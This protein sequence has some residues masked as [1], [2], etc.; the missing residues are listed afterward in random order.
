[1]LEL[2]RASAGSGKTY[3]LAKKYIWYFLTIT[4]EEEE[5]T[6]LRT[7]SELADSARHILAI[8]F[9]NKAT[10]EMQQ[11]IIR[12]LYDLAWIRT[13]SVKQQDGSVKEVMPDYMDDFCTQLD[14]KPE[15]VARVAKVALS[16]LLENYSDFNVSTID[17]FFQTV[18][19]TFAYESELNDAYQVEIDTDYLS[20]MGVDAVL[21]EIDNNE[22][23]ANTAFWVKMLMDRASTGWNIFNKKLSSTGVTPYKEF[24]DAVKKMEN[25]NYKEKRREIEEYFDKHGDDL[26]E[27]YGYFASTY[28]PPVRKAFQTFTSAT[29]DALKALPGELAQLD[30]RSVLGKIGSFYRKCLEKVGKKDAWGNASLLSDFP[31][32][33]EEVFDHKKWSEWADKNTEAEAD[34][35][36]R[37]MRVMESLAAWRAQ[38]ENPEFRHWMLYSSRIPYYALFSIV[39]RKRQEYLD[40]NNAVELGET[41]VILNGVIGDSD[42]PF[43][44]ERLGTYLNHF[45]IDEF[46]DTSKMQWINLQP[47]LSESMSHGHGN[48]II[49]DAKQSIYR[50]RNADPSLITSEVPDWVR[51][52]HQGNI[53]EKGNIPQENTNYRSELRVVQ[54]NNSLF[55]FI[56]R[57]LD[58]PTQA[59]GDKSRMEFTPLYSNVVQTPNKTKERGYVEVTFIPSKSEV[60]WPELTVQKIRQLIARGY[61]QNE[62][63]VLVTRH[64]EG[65][66]VITELSAYNARCEDKSD[67]IRFVSE[68]S[69]KVDSSTAVNIITGV[70]ANMA[71]GSFPEIRQGEDRKKRGVGNWNELAADFNYFALHHS[72]MSTSECLDAYIESGAQYNALSELL[73]ELQSLAIPAVIEAVCAK[74][75]LP[76]TRKSDA[77]YIA[78]FQD[79]ALEYCEN[80]PTDIG[81]FLQW[82]ERKRRNATIASPENE[83]AVQIVTIHKSKGL[84]Y[85]CVIVPNAD[86][87][88]E[89]NVGRKEWRWVK[90]GVISH[91]EIP[92]P[93]YLPVETVKNL[94]GTIHESELKEYYDQVKMDRLNQAYVALTRAKKEL[95][96][97]TPAPPKTPKKTAT[98]SVSMG[99]LLDRFIKQKLAEVPASAS[100]GLTLLPGSVV[101]PDPDGLRVSIGSLP[102]NVGEDRKEELQ[103]EPLTDYPS[104]VSQ[105]FLKY[106]PEELG[107]LADAGAQQDADVDDLDIRA[108]G[109]LK[110]AVLEL[111]NTPADL[112][113]AVRHL[114]LTGVIPESLADSIEADLAEALSRPEVAGWFDG[115]SRTINERSVLKRGEVLRRP[116]RMIMHSDG[117]VTVIDYK[118]GKVPTG[119]KHKNQI[120]RYVRLLRDTGRYRSVRGYLW[121]VNERAIVPLP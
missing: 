81:S 48:L 65:E 43:I 86:W 37:Y 55:Q 22:K 15:Q 97:I 2:Y 13:R 47:L 30:G 53:E 112:P 35:R 29:R 67:V 118:F 58:G 90:P 21:D 24:V 83:D 109:T 61:R 33:N 93:P 50:F 56:A 3:T 103:P 16:A 73:S 89:D 78:A 75:L 57:E 91:P 51:N 27:L 25:E 40:E 34:I 39:T 28:E 46:Q 111:V 45:L 44:Y 96:V 72:D 1:M 108:E 9:T 85:D 60:K 74:F 98:V 20:Q 7:D 117:S 63:A 69:L 84:Q 120:S 80:H 107:R 23:D 8:T 54:F 66:S 82:W 79:L 10:N 49:G 92:L 52:E 41:S 105:K 76:E 114:C 88:F 18:L 36:Q 19:R 4:P 95:Y 70:L 102:D 42:A 113:V 87:V 99:T 68:Q 106:H 121:Y 12:A 115:S 59:S 14:V 100:S 62:I 71:R 104:V 11:R 101:A 38:V 119:N 32:F 5:I 116:D 26:K 64:S 17:S 94:E 77:V 110:H 31:E 6:R